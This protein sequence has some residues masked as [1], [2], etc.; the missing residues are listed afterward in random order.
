MGDHLAVTMPNCSSRF[1][2]T[3]RKHYGT[4]NRDNMIDHYM[5]DCCHCEN[6]DSPV[7]CK[8]SGDAWAKLNSDE[9]VACHPDYD[10]ATSATLN[11]IFEGIDGNGDGH[12][13]KAEFRRAFTGNRKVEFRQAFAS[14]G[15]DWKTVFKKLQKSENGAVTLAAFLEGCTAALTSVI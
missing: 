9:H 14:H 10:F 5:W 8:M 4:Y 15:L 13:D 12:I 3:R 1:P 2:S 7:C 11:Q 6:S